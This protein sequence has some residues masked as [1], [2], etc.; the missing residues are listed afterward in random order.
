MPKPRTITAP[1]KGD[2]AMIRLIMGNVHVGTPDND[3]EQ[4][5]RDRVAKGTAKGMR[6]AAGGRTVRAWIAAYLA[7]H[8]RNQDAYRRVMGGRL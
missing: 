1:R 5:A 2:R 6:L 7:E 4:M 3:V 8:R